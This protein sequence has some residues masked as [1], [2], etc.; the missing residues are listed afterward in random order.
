[1]VFPIAPSAGLEISQDD[2]PLPG[3]L[4]GPVA[5]FPVGGVISGKN[6]NLPADQLF[7]AQGFE[8]VN[9]HHYNA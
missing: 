1:M 5:C 7:S 2:G 9:P 8:V 4:S 6:R 3:P